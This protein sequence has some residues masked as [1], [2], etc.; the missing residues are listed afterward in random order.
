MPDS[1]ETH[2]P[3]C[4][5]Y[6]PPPELSG[7]GE[8]MGQAIKEDLEKGIIALKL[9]FALSKSSG[10]APPASSGAESDSVKTDGTKLTLRSVLHYLWDESG[11]TKWSPRME[12]RRSWFV[13][14][15][16]VS[17]AAQGKSAK[18]AALG[19]SLYVP[20]PFYPDRKD[21]IA[22]RRDAKFGD[23][24][25][26]DKGA[27]KLM[28]LV[29]EVKEICPARYGHK[30]VIKQV[31]DC[32]FM[33]A[34][35]VY[36]RLL[37]RFEGELVLWEAVEGSHL[38]AIATF[39]VGPT[40]VASIEE[41]ALMVTTE[42]W[43]PFDG[44]QEKS[45]IDILTEQ[46][47]RFVKGMCYNLPSNRPLA[48]V[49]LSDTQPTPTGMYIIGADASAEYTA[50]IEELAENSSL[51]HWIWRVGAES[52]PHF[53]TTTNASELLAAAEAKRQNIG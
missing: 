22:R 45:L 11:M 27:R 2:S 36:K 29:G 23:L 42:N 9:D 12:G 21:D 37:K 16:Y 13:I 4:E 14:H 48:S 19:N 40:G 24:Q 7:L 38:M 17:E 51:A 10:R 33:L 35:D 32:P 46:S 30:V 20:E 26:Q 3:H 49:V 52:M 8:V 1:G 43:I 39:G 34:E 31:P 5:S 41:I 15:K 53:P 28:I 18:G 47:R 25:R 6:E 44:V 50:A